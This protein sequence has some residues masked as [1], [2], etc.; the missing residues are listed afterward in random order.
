MTIPALRKLRAI[1][2]KAHISLHT[3]AW[4]TAIFQ[5]ADF[6]DEILSLSEPSKTLI[7]I[8][9]EAKIWRKKNF[10]IAILFTNSFQTAL[11]SKL[12]KAKKTFGYKNEGRGFLL[13]NPI[14]KPLWKGSRHEAFYYLNLI[15]EVERYYFEEKSTISEEKLDVTLNIS[16]ER[17]NQA[18]KFLTSFGVDLERKTVALGVGSTN[19]LAKRWH[20]EGYADLANK[21]ANTIGL[22]VILLGSK[23]E[24]DVSQEVFEKSKINPIILTGKTNLSEVVGV[25]SE[26]DLLISNDMGLAHLAP[27]LGTKTLVI[28]GPT[29]PKTTKPLGSEIIRK[30]LDCAPCMLRECPID[31]PCMTQIS[32]EE[33]FEKARKILQTL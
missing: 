9:N 18:R 31:H 30:E 16:D 1:F 17:K 27:A 26:V 2:P 20:T 19:S 28:F 15:S 13:T 10:D 21:L 32:A 33:V 24:I 14:E 25:L 22:N 4:A 8:K 3:R 11:L 7:P 5:E 6:I 12:G 23:N 29:N